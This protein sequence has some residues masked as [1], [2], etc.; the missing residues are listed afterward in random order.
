VRLNCQV[1]GDGE[2]FA[3][4]LTNRRN[5]RRHGDYGGCHATK[6]ANGAFGALQMKHVSM[7]LCLGSAWKLSMTKSA[8]KIMEVKSGL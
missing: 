1:L 5:Q 8:W 7:S 4:D 6:H 2:V 3:T